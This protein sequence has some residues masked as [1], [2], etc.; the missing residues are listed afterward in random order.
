VPAPNDVFAKYE[1]ELPPVKLPIAEKR[2]EILNSLEKN[3]VIIIRAATGSGKSSQVPQY[4]LEDAYKNWQGYAYN[5]N[6]MVN[7]IVTQ[8]RRISAQSL[9]KRVALERK[10]EIGSLVGYQIGLDRK[11]SN[12]DTRLLYCTTGV[13]LQK[14]IN[15]KSLAKWSHIIID[16]IHERDLDMDFVLLIQR[17]L[18]TAKNTGTKLILMSA[19]METETISNYFKTNFSPQSEFTPVILDLDVKRPHPVKVDYLDSFKLYEYFGVTQDNID[20]K[21][22]AIEPIMYSAGVKILDLLVQKEMKKFLVFLPGW[23]E[24]ECF[25]K[26][27]LKHANYVLRDFTI[28]KLHS[29]MGMDDIQGLYDATIEKKII[30]STNIAESS[31]TI[32][33][34]D[35]VIDYCLM[36]HLEA[37]TSSNLTQLKLV[38]ASKVNLKQRE[39]RVGR[40]K[41]GQVVRMIFEE[42]YDKIPD[43]A[44][45]EMQRTSLETVVL[46]AKQLKMGKPIDILG[47]AMNPPPR[48]SIVDAVLV[49]KE[50]GALTR[51]TDNKF[52]YE[53]GD[54]TF[55]GEIMSNLPVD[56]RFSKLI[57]LG[58]MFNVL[59]EMIIIAAGLSVRSIFRQITIKSMESFETKFRFGSGSS[60]VL[61]LLNV[62]KEWT[63][64]KDQK[65]GKFEE[66]NFV[67]TNKLDWRNLRDMR[68]Q[69][70]D[71]MK[72]LMQLGFSRESLVENI[73][74]KYSERTFL[75][76]C[77]IAGKF[78]T[79]ILNFF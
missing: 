15:E 33:D 51:Y 55:V 12:T 32:P 3:D 58:Y 42:H 22:P 31:I 79:H 53:D 13:F 17:R 45:A 5:K 20:L 40:T 46:K 66:M 19:T 78:F 39:G 75:I 9:A 68:A 30:I 72:R 11:V 48:C 54:L 77:C 76:K 65:L 43:E 2:K 38:W 70:D 60:D 67:Q 73:V 37:D 63:K 52:D 14:L 1:F 26:Q 21:N 35:F 7:I 4:I 69:V 49:L 56:V 27:L 16:E 71:I 28:I 23:F 24:I 59:K 50:L 62:Y 61:A 10:C 41:H 74:E 25:H 29:T 36:K 47:L 18:M 34:I 8:P 6:K 44:P 64:F 57:L